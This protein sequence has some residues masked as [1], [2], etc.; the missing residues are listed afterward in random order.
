MRWEAGVSP[1]AAVAGGA[2]AGPYGLRTLVPV[3]RAERWVQPI[4]PLQGQAA[5]SRSPRTRQ[6][7][8]D[9]VLALVGGPAGEG[10]DGKDEEDGEEGNEDGDE[11]EEEDEEQEAEE[12]EEDEEEEGAPGSVS[13]P[14]VV[15]RVAESEAS[16]E[17]EPREEIPHDQAA[18]VASSAAVVS[19]AAAAEVVP[20]VA[21]APAVAPPAA[22]SIDHNGASDERGP[23]PAWYL[24]GS[25]PLFC[26]GKD[27]DAIIERQAKLATRTLA[28]MG[29]T[30][31]PPTASSLLHAAS[32]AAAQRLLTSDLDPV[33]STSS[34]LSLAQTGADLF[35]AAVRETYLTARGRAAVFPSREVMCRIERC[36][37]LDPELSQETNPADMR[38]GTVLDALQDLRDGLQWDNRQTLSVHNTIHRL[39]ENANGSITGG[40]AR[41]MPFPMAM[42]WAGKGD[43]LRGRV[44]LSSN[45][46]QSP[47]LTPAL[48]PALE[49]LGLPPS[50]ATTSSS[51][52]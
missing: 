9:V 2:P 31:T 12:D 42:A 38:L 17:E 46:R 40:L 20:T 13:Q 5:P 22:S 27:Q 7:G 11:N 44:C 19:A 15:H 51:S 24:V 34:A 6:T 36:Q 25:S 52:N 47:F 21:A 10:E 18:A 48:T 37:H 50:G 29:R 4:Q 3:G 16:S 41:S 45:E 39:A 1:A 26:P 32:T 23:L 49:R 33:S 43:V 30:Q 35:P 8:A 28:A 14:P